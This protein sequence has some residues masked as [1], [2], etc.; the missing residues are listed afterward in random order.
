M[1]WVRLRDPS[2]KLTSFA[3]FGTNP[4]EDSETIIA[5]YVSRWNSEVTLQEL[6][7]YLGVETQRHWSDRAVARTTLCLPHPGRQRGCPP[8]IV[9]RLDKDTSELLLVAKDDATLVALG[10]EMRPQET[11]S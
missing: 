7:A 4:Q 8:G 9:H 11:W 6:W 1:R 5:R 2:E 3:L 10:S